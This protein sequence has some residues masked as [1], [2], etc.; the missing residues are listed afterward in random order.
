M[1]AREHIKDRIDTLIKYWSCIE[2]HK[3]LS[4]PHLVFLLHEINDLRQDLVTLGTD[5]RSRP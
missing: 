5:K 2:R 1:E 3:H 4:H